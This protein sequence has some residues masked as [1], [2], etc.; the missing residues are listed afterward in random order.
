MRTVLLICL[1]LAIVLL[2]MHSLP[3]ATAV[4]RDRVLGA[5]ANIIALQTEQS[6]RQSD[7]IIQTMHKRESEM[8]REERNNSRLAPKLKMAIV[9]PIGGPSEIPDFPPPMPKVPKDE[10]GGARGLTPDELLIQRAADFLKA[11]II[12]KPEDDNVDAKAIEAQNKALLTR[13]ADLEFP[14]FSP[15]AQFIKSKKNEPVKA[16][17][18]ESAENYANAL[19]QGRKTSKW[20]VRGQ[21]FKLADKAEEKAGNKLSLFRYWSN[22]PLAIHKGNG[23]I[24]DADAIV[25]PVTLTIPAR[26]P[27]EF[28]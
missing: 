6:Q 5:L 16:K 27:V 25:K 7:D 4:R 1:S 18:S 19:M 11:K 26:D 21:D 24:I 23:R 8:T 12:N 2:S 10:A 20:S 17:I 15:H 28:P 13:A 22:K 3:T 9:A 14:R